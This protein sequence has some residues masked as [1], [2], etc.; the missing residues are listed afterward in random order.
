MGAYWK[1]LE[2]DPS[3]AVAYMHLGHIYFNRQQFDHAVTQYQSAIRL[4]P[5]LRK[6]KRG[7]AFS[8]LGEKKFFRALEEWF[9]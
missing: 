2:L 5:T 8:F 3:V 1:V 7:L 9:T 6:A 4:D